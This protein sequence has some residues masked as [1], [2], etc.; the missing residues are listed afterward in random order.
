M[1]K[2]FKKKKVIRYIAPA[3]GWEALSPESRGKL[4]LKEKLEPYFTN[5][6]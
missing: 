2:V 1:K 4:C 5:K 6:Q 3:E